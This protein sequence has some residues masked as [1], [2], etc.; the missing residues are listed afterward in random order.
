MFRPDSGR[1]SNNLNNYEDEVLKLTTGCSV[2]VTGKIVE[3]PA[4]GQDFELAATDVKVVGWVED[5][6]TY[7][8]AK[9]RRSI[10]YLH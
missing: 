5:A 9:T 1:G 6:D 10:E 7:P 2:E 8:M 4:K 3:S